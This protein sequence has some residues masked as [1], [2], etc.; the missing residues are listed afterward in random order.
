MNKLLK[1]KEDYN[2]ILVLDK[3]EN[4]NYLFKEMEKMTK[5]IIISTRNGFK[6]FNENDN[7]NK[8]CKW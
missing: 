5:D 1:L 4:S 2:L 3:Y 8:R 6:S 7:R